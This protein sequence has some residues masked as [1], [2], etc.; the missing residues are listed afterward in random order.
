MGQGV[1]HQRDTQQTVK[2][3]TVLQQQ[4]S[5]SVATTSSYSHNRELAA[6]LIDR[7]IEKKVAYHLTKT[8]GRERVENHIDWLEWKQKNDPHSI[9]TNPAG[10]LR[11]AIEY[12]YASE[13]HKGFQTRKQKTAARTA[14]KKYLQAQ[15]QLLD[16]RNREQRALSQQREKERAKRLEMLREQYHSTE[17]EA[18]IWTQA[19]KS[20][21]DQIPE[22]SFNAYLASSTL[23]ALHDGRAVMAVPNRFVG[24]RIERQLATKIQQIL[25]TH[26]SGQTV[27]IQCVALDETE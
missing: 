7:G 21:K 1:S 25:G 14:Q 13:G 24:E 22:A 12:D 4:Q 23:L 18:K 6:A 5:K 10:L 16:E 2:Q 8:Y 19:L 26:L 20:L 15:Q 17:Q 27:A 9:K 11:R 3:Q